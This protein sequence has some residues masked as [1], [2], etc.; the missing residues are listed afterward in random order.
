M[1]FG[2]ILSYRNSP[3]W[4]RTGQKIEQDTNLSHCPFFEFLCVSRMMHSDHFPEICL[5]HSLCQSAYTDDTCSLEKPLFIGA[6]ETPDGH[7]NPKRANTPDTLS[8]PPDDYLLPV[9]VEMSVIRICPLWWYKFF[10]RFHNG[11]DWEV[12][13]NHGCTVRNDP[14]MRQYSQ[15][16]Q[17]LTESIPFRQTMMLY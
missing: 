13:I 17:P 4:A 5:S 3:A 12:N 14:S 2:T 7:W 10:K 6:C 11:S 15:R 1:C 8:T 9:Y 16:G